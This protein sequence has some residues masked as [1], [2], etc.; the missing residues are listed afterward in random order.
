MAA[1]FIAIAE[2]TEISGI[3]QTT[4]SAEFADIAEKIDE[5][6]VSVIDEFAAVAEAAIIAKNTGTAVFAQVSGLLANA[7]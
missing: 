2:N 4:V 3:A 1:D 7:H 5:T 6:E